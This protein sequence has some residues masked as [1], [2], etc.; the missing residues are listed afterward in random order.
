MS[1]TVSK[2]EEAACLTWFD[3][4]GNM[5][6]KLIKYKD[7][8][9]YIHTI[10]CIHAVV[11]SDIPATV[12]YHCAIIQSDRRKEFQLTYFKRDHTWK[13]YWKYT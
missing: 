4:N 11:I 10:D 7:R 3:V 6:P 9:G 2:Y 5:Y 12:I 1:Y 8:E 13:I